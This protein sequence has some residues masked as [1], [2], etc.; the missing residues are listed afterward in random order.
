[1]KRLLIILPFLV[2]VS[3]GNNRL[4][5][6]VVATH[7]NGQP[8]T[9]YYFNSE[10]QRVAEKEFYDNGILK[11]EGTVANGLRNGPWTSYFPDGKVQSTGFYTDGIRTGKAQVFFENGQL[12][13]DG[14]YTDDHKC[15]EWVFYDEQGYETERHFYGACD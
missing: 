7:A 9:I 8:A 2:L 10:H 1:M 12:W 3:C 6:Q 4:K 11:M 13:M 5:E 14:F 15:G